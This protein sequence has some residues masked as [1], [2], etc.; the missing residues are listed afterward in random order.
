MIKRSKTALRESKT[1]N[2]DTTLKQLKQID[3]RWVYS[4]NTGTFNVYKLIEQGEDPKAA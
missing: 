1:D 4:T 2:V 3:S